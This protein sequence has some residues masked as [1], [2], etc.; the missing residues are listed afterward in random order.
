VLCIFVGEALL[1]GPLGND[2]DV[3]GLKDGIGISEG[4]KAGAIDDAIYK[5]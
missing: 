2:D 5:M 1:P 4:S 3:V